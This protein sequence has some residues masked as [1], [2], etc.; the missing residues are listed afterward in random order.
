MAKD[1][2][3]SAVVW[4]LLLE[5]KEPPC[6]QRDTEFQVNAGAHVNRRR[7]RSSELLRPDLCRL[8]FTAER[9]FVGVH[10]TLSPD[11]KNKSIV[12]DALC[13]DRNLDDA[14]NLLNEMKQK[15]IRPNIVTYSSLIDGLCNSVQ[16]ENV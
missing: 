6:E 11:I 14:I 13:K 9:A 1:R 10:G 2:I 7:T 3:P 15:G 16:W 8:S 5:I 12:I 4:G